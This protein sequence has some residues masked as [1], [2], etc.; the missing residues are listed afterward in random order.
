M[1]QLA[2][3]H[4]WACLQCLAIT[5]FKWQLN[6]FLILREPTTILEELCLHWIGSLR[7]R[8]SSVA[9]RRN[10]RWKQEGLRTEGRMKLEDRKAKREGMQRMVWGD[11]QLNLALHLEPSFNAPLTS[12]WGVKKRTFWSQSTGTCTVHSEHALRSLCS[13]P[14]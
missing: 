13:C 5:V 14:F 6:I 3:I 8:A 11:A 10:W 9:R 12:R 4:L 1:G 7:Q 2:F